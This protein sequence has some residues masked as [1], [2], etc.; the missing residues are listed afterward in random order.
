MSLFSYLQSVE[1]EAPL[2]CLQE[3]ATCSDPDPD[4]LNTGITLLFPQDLF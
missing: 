4:K 1:P 3:P 2:P